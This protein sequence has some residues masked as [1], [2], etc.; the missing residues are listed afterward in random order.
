MPVDLWIWVAFVGFI[1]GML[2]L[3]LLVF[4]RQVHVVTMR[5]AAAWSVVW[6]ALGLAFGGLVWLWRGGSAA[7]EYLAGY[8]LTPARGSK[9]S[10]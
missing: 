8:L 4:H 1:A 7:G 6:V 3:D 9:P 10:G 2:A 5:E